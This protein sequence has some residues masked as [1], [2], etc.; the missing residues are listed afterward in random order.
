[1]PKDLT[2]YHTFQCHLRNKHGYCLKTCSPTI[3]EKQLGEKSTSNSG[4]GDESESLETDPGSQIQHDPIALSENR[5][6][7]MYILN[8]K[9]QYKT[10]GFSTTDTS[11]GAK[12]SV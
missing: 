7:A 6:D 5:S 9:E 10:V 11:K 2:N 4:A 12:M 1:M 8:L 3:G